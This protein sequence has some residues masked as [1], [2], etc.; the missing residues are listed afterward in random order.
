[1]K[2]SHC[3]GQRS[4]VV[5]QYVPARPMVSVKVRSPAP[6]SMTAGTPYLEP[7]HI[8][9]LTD[10]GPDDPLT[11]GA[12]CPNRHGEIHHGSNGQKRN[13]ELQTRI[14]RKEMASRGM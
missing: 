5:R 2:E 13:S 6:F 7:H 11:M 9:R 4:D 3:R 8:G 14:T 10:E 1:M 12:V